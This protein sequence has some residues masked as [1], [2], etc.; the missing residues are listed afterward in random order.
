MSE[1]I[2]FEY[3]LASRREPVKLV[4]VGDCR[5]GYVLCEY[6]DNRRFPCRIPYA[7]IPEHNRQFIDESVT[8]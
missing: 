8:S 7:A 6:A 4:V 3:R 2:P 1:Q 5:K